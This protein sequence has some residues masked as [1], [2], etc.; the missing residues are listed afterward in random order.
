[1]ATSSPVIVSRI[2]NRRGT[3]A[4]FD[5]LY[6][7]GYKG[8]GG[9]T[10]NKVLQPGE[11][12]LCL[13]SRRVF[14]GTLNGEYIEFGQGAGTGGGGTG[15]F[16][17]EPLT[18][19][20]APSSSFIAIPAL[21]LSTTPFFNI[22]YS[23]ADSATTLGAVGNN[24]ARN[25]TLTITATKSNATLTDN[26]TS[27]TDNQYELDFIAELSSNGADIQVKYRH[28]F[29]SALTLTTGTMAWAAF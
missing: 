25:G 18:L 4:E 8:V 9:A 29:P 13:D 10:G 27:I 20:L 26:Y 28:N 21:S 17:F 3:Q 2:Q 11:I 16:S 19:S 24:Y 15:T 23:A 6:P 22:F 5:S 14:I 12:G 1:M 7:P